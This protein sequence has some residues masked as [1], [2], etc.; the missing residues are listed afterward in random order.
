GG[1]G[2][3]PLRTPGPRPSPIHDSGQQPDEYRLTQEDPIAPLMAFPSAFA[4]SLM[5]SDWRARRRWVGAGSGRGVCDDGDATLAP[6]Y[7]SRTSWAGQEGGPRSILAEL[8]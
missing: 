6:V 5:V 7:P 3:V 8:R 1:V 4:L 2:F